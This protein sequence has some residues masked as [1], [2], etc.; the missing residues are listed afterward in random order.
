MSEKYFLKYF[1]TKHFTRVAKKP[2]GYPPKQNPKQKRNTCQ[3]KRLKSQNG[4]LG[5]REKQKDPF[6]IR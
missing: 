3:T 1:L 6:S 5:K 2:N 4:S